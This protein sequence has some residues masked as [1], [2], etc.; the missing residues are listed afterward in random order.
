[1]DINITEPDLNEFKSSLSRLRDC[2]M[3]GYTMPQFCIDNDIKKPLFVALNSD[4]RD[5][6]WQLHVQFQ[7]DKRLVA[8]FALI[9][10]KMKRNYGFGSNI[11]ELQVKNIDELQLSDYD[12]IIALGFDDFQNDGVLNLKK[13]LNQFLKRTY[14]DIPALHFLQ[15]NPGVKIIQL[16]SPNLN[17]HKNL[18][19]LEKQ[20]VAYYKEKKSSRLYILPAEIE[21][22][23]AQGQ[24]VSTPYDFLGYTNQEVYNLLKTPDRIVNA[25]GSV[26]LVDDESLG[27][28]DGKRMT[29]HQPK[30]FKNR[31]YF[32]GDCVS[33]GYGVPWDKTVESWLQ[34]LL[35]ENNFDYR[36][37]NESQFIFARHQDLFYNWDKFPAKSGDIVFL[38]LGPVSKFIPLLDVSTILDR[39]HDYGEVFPDHVHINELGHKALADYIFKFLVDN[40]FFRDVVNSYPPPRGY[41]IDMEY[42]KKIF[43]HCKV[44]LKTKSS[45]SIRQNFAQKD[46]K[47]ERLS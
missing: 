46:F 20:Y 23:Q 19:E 9:H 45:K 37:E 5:F 28:R 14:I 22:A 17:R 38:K 40:N 42:R 21:K 27:I 26:S 41:I 24:T 16:S 3:A 18:N 25:D 36:V 29:A 10:G 47:S 35:N 34:K 8:E 4:C 6:L 43:P 30:K 7:Y 13:L 44:F 1:M 12:K 15:K 39:P 33:F 2:F 32:L 11:P 31:I